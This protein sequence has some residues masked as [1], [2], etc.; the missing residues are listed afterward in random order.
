MTNVADPGPECDP[1]VLGVVQQ[2]AQ[3]VRGELAGLSGQLRMI[4]GD[5]I[6]PRAQPLIDAAMRHAEAMD[7]MISRVMAQISGA[8]PAP[9]PSDGPSAGPSTGASTGAPTGPEPAGLLA[10]RRVLVVDETLPTLRLLTALLTSEGARVV[11]AQTGAEAVDILAGERFDLLITDATLQGLSGAQ[12]IQA[13]RA[14]PGALAATPALAMTSDISVQ[15][16]DEL[17]AAGASRV[18]TKPLPDPAEMLRIVARLLKA[19]G[20]GAAPGPGEDAAIFDPGPLTRVCALAGPQVGREILD[21]LMLDLIETL[22]RL[23][24]VSSGLHAAG[25]GAGGGGAGGGGAGFGAGGDLVEL[26]ATTHVLIALA[27][28]AGASLLLRKVQTLDYRLQYDPRTALPPDLGALLFDIRMLTR[29]AVAAIARLALPR[30]GEASSGGPNSGGPSS[31]GRTA[32]GLGQS[33][34]GQSAPGQGGPLL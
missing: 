20:E 5:Q 34:P 10:G 9:A 33:A 14:R 23:D 28:T 8:A 21:R 2:C 12:V 24:R 29:G 26:R 19:Q 1:Q 17:I 22:A 16:H 25:G 32:G 15:R 4:P 13:L 3:D 7:R 27:G 30:S 18:V 6:G 11:I 31:G